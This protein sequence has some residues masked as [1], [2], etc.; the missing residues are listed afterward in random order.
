[1]K[2]LR[3]FLLSLF[4]CSCT[5]ATAQQIADPNF[6]A[7]VAH[8]AYAKNGP[9]VLFDEAHHNFH[10]ASGRYKPFADLIANDGYRVV[11]NRAP[12]SRDT[13]RDADVLIIA[14]A[15]GAEG[16]GQPG[17]SESA[18]TEAECDAVR[19]W[20]EGGGDLLLI[21]DHAPM[22]AAAS[23]LAKRLGVDLS[24]GA[25]TDPKNSEENATSLVFSAD[26]RL[27]GDHPITRGRDDS[28]RV[29]R[30]RT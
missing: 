15:L 4:L 19:A 8:P 24:Q 29:R 16:M 3:F 28:E 9:K 12:F 5:T 2:P 6:D 26:N 27:L 13:L 14:N 21:T 17:A 22:G 20:V 18:F 30:V 23:R 25:V 10:T 7:K 11:P 1:M